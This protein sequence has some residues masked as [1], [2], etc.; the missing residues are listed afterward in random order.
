MLVALLLVGNAHHSVGQKKEFAQY[1][2]SIDQGLSQNTVNCIIKDK[3]GFVWLGT[4][5]GLNRFD[6]VEVTI[7]SES[8]N[9]AVGLLNSAVTCL[10]EDKKS[11]LIYIGTNG[12]GLSVYNP[13][14]ETFVHHEY[15]GSDNCILSDFVHAMVFDKHGD[16]WI[17]TANGISCFKVKD[18]VFDNYV[19]SVDETASFP[20]LGAT[21]IFIDT[22]G[23]VWAGTYGKG[24]VKLNTQT[25]TYEAYPCSVG[26][27]SHYNNNLVEDIEQCEDPNALL[28]ATDSGFYRFNKQTGEYQ[29]LEFE[30]VIVNDIEIGPDNDIWLSSSGQGLMHISKEGVATNYVKNP[31]DIHSLKENY[32]QCIY[33]D[34]RGH[35]WVGT[36]SNGFIHLNISKNQFVHYYQTNDEKGINGHS[37]FAL[38]KDAKGNVWVGTIEGLS[39]WNTKS[40]EIDKYYPFDN[41]KQISVWAM[42]YDVDD[43]LWLGTTRGLVRHNVVTK[44]NKVYTYKEGDEHSLPNNE[45]YAI[46]R[47]AKGRL[48]LGTAFGLAR[49]DEE[50]DAFHSYYSGVEDG[51]LSYDEIWD[52]HCDSKGYLW[53]TT[54]RGLN[55]YQDHNDSFK[56]LYRN[57]G[58][59]ISLCSSNVL[60][61][62]E[63]A[64]GRI[65]IAT[66]NGVNQVDREM[67]VISRIGLREGLNN[68]YTY[69]VLE[70]NN[71]LWISTNKGIDRVNL[72]TK[73]VINYDV[74][75]G[76]QSNEF[77][78]VSNHLKDGRFLFGGLNGFNVFHP[79]SIKKSDFEPP[80]YFTSL[81]LYGKPIS[82]RD[83]TSW[84]DVVINS[85]LIE[86]SHL[87]FEPDERFFTLDF[88]ALDYQAPLQ[89]QY[90]YRMLPNSDEWIPVKSQRQL[91]FINLSAGKYQLD[92]RSTNAEGYL[93][94]NNKRLNITVNPSLWEEPWFVLACI[95]FVII[96]VFIM[97]RYR[98]HR[99][100]KDKDVLE[101]RVQARTT[102][103]QAQR[104]IANHQRDEIA[105]QKSELEGFARELEF[106][107]EQRTEELVKA[108]EAAEESDRLKSAFLSNM[109]HEIRT[110]MNAIMGFSE[111]L[112][113]NSF[114]EDEKMDF[115]NLI[116]TNG[117]N[118]LHLLNDIIDISMIESGQ[119]KTVLSELDVTAL[120]KDVFETFKT[121]KDLI[122]KSD[123]NYHLECSEQTVLIK[124]D[125]FRLR[126]IL[127]NLISNAIKFT[128]SGYINVSVK[129]VGEQVLICVEDSGIGISLKHQ[130]RI[131]DRFL[132]VENS[133][134]NLYAGNGL[135]LTITKNLIEILNGKIG[136][137]S[138][139]GVGTS[140]YFHLPLHRSE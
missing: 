55:I 82:M 111:L 34:E 33:L 135:G 38:E 91:T 81:D 87:Y 49:L 5:D 60:S 15:D 139:P 46:E 40:G 113:D 103:I 11:N 101:R 51:A 43:I 2:F 138:E 92:I 140:F 118:L 131:F 71:E 36:K 3:R 75:D 39:V 129:T 66:D 89:I 29:L 119:L 28:V 90:Y 93:C 128:E 77:N 65:W 96:L 69:R 85:S 79:D 61:V 6:G 120:V 13:K 110:P 19:S 115:A 12:G 1:N 107:V 105:R 114:S 42:Y 9:P 72:N 98:M 136:I 27:L 84:D 48:W 37:V 23:V 21:K 116:R 54:K 63:D 126:Q 137:E 88:A 74:Q 86:A 134:S 80:I 78:P 99:L 25:K 18:G 31:H 102:E 64:K 59:S 17:A 50:T 112:L 7:F 41:K 73:E 70:N 94:N 58:D 32:L 123:I 45:V 24:I 22:D 47:D 14:N 30:G 130:S 16:I 83:T 95:I 125:A 68:A 109:S 53:I 44:K 133:T 62:N 100:Q 117:D 97:V 57:Q 4:E 132:K 122:A 104:N 52:I 108:K 20:D 127:N 56:C 35:L 121:S 76:L 67:N 10:L 106:K 8:E 26:N 124:S